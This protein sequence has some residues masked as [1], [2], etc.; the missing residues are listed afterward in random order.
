MI[1]VLRMHHI[2]PD[3]GYCSVRKRFSVMVPY[4]KLSEKDAF[5]I[6]KISNFGSVLLNDV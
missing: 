3:V 4:F 1:V 2:P 6:V 5:D